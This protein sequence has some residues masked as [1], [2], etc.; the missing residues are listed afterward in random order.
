M[1]RLPSLTMRTDV[2]GEPYYAPQFPAGTAPQMPAPPGSA[3]AAPAG[4]ASGGIQLGTLPNGGK[5]I[6]G[7]I[8]G[9]TPK[10]LAD[11]GADADKMMKAATPEDPYGLKGAIKDVVSN[12]GGGLRKE[13]LGPQEEQN[14]KGAGDEVNSLVTKAQSANQMQALVVDMRNK[15]AQGILSGGVQGAPF[16]SKI[17]NI[18]AAMGAK[19]ETIDKL[20]NT[21]A[22]SADSGH[23]IAQ[24]VSQFAGARIAARELTFFENIK[25]QLVQTP[26]G[27][28]Q[29]YQ[30]LYNISDR[31]KQQ[32]SQAQEYVNDPKNLGKGLGGFE[33]KFKEVKIPSL[34]VP[35]LPD[36]A[37]RKGWKATGDDGVTYKSDGARWVR[38]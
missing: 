4:A 27:R 12:I 15:E 8:V 14:V 31:I 7:P 23:L 33:P 20:Q 36:P 38:Q 19:G 25:P 28:E 32:A 37:S 5:I 26:E 6:Q 35:G 13:K 1:P 29:I 2:S 18:A 9:A 22:W 24:A 30:A 3:P 21:Q 11:V 17:A 10:M 16:F 34:Q